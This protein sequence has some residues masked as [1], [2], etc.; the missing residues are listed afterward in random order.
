MKWTLTLIIAAVGYCWLTVTVSLLLLGKRA[1]GSYMVVPYDWNVCDENI[2]LGLTYFVASVGSGRFLAVLLDSCR[3][4]CV[5]WLSCLVPPIIAS[6]VVLAATYFAVDE[7]VGKY[8]RRHWVP[9][10]FRSIPAFAILSAWL[11]FPRIAGKGDCKQIDNRPLEH[12]QFLSYYG[13]QAADQDTSPALVVVATIGLSLGIVLRLAQGSLAAAIV[14]HH[15][16]VVATLS[17]GLAVPL[18]CANAIVFAA[19]RNR[20]LYRLTMVLGGLLAAIAVAFL[21]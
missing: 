2:L 9:I 12:D 14:P 20:P 13:Q 11:T 8:I 21:F 10:A 18:A 16:L 1:G 6:S 17:L 3:S 7:D 5:Q 19:N 15:V 4:L